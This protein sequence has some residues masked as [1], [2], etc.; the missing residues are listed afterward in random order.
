[1][2]KALHRKKKDIYYMDSHLGGELIAGSRPLACSAGY[3]TYF[4]KLFGLFNHFVQFKDE[5]IFKCLNPFYNGEDDKQVGSE[6][7]E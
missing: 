2:G 5:Y 1:M 3:Q 7:V 4:C 6:E